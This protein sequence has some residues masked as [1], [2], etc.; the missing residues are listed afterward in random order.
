MLAVEAAVAGAAAHL[1]L[2]DPVAAA[3][4]VT[5]C[6]PK[7]FAAAALADGMLH[8]A[9]P[10]IA[11]VERLRSLVPDDAEPAVHYGLTSQDVV[12]TAAMLVTRAALEPILDRA[13]AVTDLLAALATRY[14]DAPQAGRTLLQQAA[15]TTFGAACAARLVAVTEATVA[16]V[17]QR[18]ARLAVQLGGPVA[19]LATAGTAGPALV[20][21]V[22]RRLGLA[23]PVLPWHTGRG[24][25]GSLASALG[26]LAAELAAVAQDV[27]LLSSSE[28]GEVAV[29]RAGGSSAMAHKRNPAPAVLAV[30]SAHRTPGL[31]ATLLAGMPQELQR[32]AGRWQAEVPTLVELLRLTG[33][34]AGHVRD[35]LDGLVVDQARMRAAASALAAATGGDPSDPDVGG[36][37]ALVDRALAFHRSLR[38]PGRPRSGTTSS[39]DADHGDHR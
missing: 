33:A 20:A 25:I 8:H 31:V 3:A 39:P 36:A 29:A 5:A 19:T 4:V 21:D 7:A 10:V 9:T 14:R 35:A 32:A 38:P 15:P 1:G 34:T 12:D 18:D 22:A 17:E 23:V 6:D 37:A 11:L 2:V 30:A 24:R 13:W 27:V 26:V 28:I 16:L